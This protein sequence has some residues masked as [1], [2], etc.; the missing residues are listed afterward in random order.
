MRTEPCEPQ[1]DGSG[2]VDGWPVEPRTIYYPCSL[3]FESIL[4]R[5]PPFEDYVNTVWRLPR[6]E[7]RQIQERR[8]LTQVER[9][10]SIPFY[11][12]H[13]SEA[14]LEPGDVRTLD[15]LE[16]LPIVS[17][18]DIKAD[19]DR[20][21]PW[22]SF[23][24]VGPEDGERTPMRLVTS[25][26]TTGVPRPMF[27]PAWD[28]EVSAIVGSRVFYLHDVRPGMVVQVV[29]GLST[30]NGGIHGME[31]LWKYTGAVPLTTGGG[32]ATPTEMQIEMARQYG[33]QGL[34]GFPDYIRHIG[35]RAVELG[36]DPSRDL[37]VRVISTMLGRQDRGYL[38][39]LFGA[40]V[41]DSYG[42]SEVGGH[43]S[44]ECP[45]QAGRHVLE[46][47]YAMEIVDMATGARVE[48]G[49]EGNVVI[50]SLFKSAAPMIRYN[51][52]D[53]STLLPERC[54][55]GSEMVLQ[56]PILGRA[57]DLVKVKGMWVHPDAVG[58]VVAADERTTREFVCILE[59]VPRGK[60]EVDQM[61]VL[62]EPVAGVDEAAL[63]G[64]LTDRLKA[65]FGVTMLVECADEATLEPLTLRSANRTGKTRRL[66]DRKAGS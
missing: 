49:T 65:Q 7:L 4:R 9:A 52:N 58:A 47:V 30:V 32:N 46:D 38:E 40:R 28:R 43:V 20:N 17:V 56:G 42:T 25:G 41:Y 37:D 15:D 14:G 3:D 63:V 57:D 8:F 53:L 2:D 5:Y 64:D 11:R 29:N 23:Q 18:Y 51:T 13:W 44:T 12:S 10:W 50:T 27:Y 26:G 61:R 35:E 1:I 66:I 6:E 22:G 45:E 34:L 54:P 36:L 55:C 19:L 24:A 39:E 48:P 60:G 21:P 62:V 33:S 16:R 31:C 59:K